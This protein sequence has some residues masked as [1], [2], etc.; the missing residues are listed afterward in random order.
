MKAND[1][2]RVRGLDWP[3]SV[4][5]VVTLEPGDVPASSGMRLS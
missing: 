3:V 4:H 1:A 5:E 2:H